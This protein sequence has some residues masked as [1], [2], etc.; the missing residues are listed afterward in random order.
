M[1]NALRGAYTEEHTGWKNQYT[2]LTFRVH[3]W[4]EIERTKK[5]GAA[6]KF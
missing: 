4:N 3:R 1:K 5:G 2:L 6:K